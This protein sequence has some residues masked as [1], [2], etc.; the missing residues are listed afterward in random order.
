[1]SASS[2]KTPA[3]RYVFA[4]LAT[5][6]D[7]V[8][9]PL[10]WLILRVFVGGALVLE[11]WPKIMAPLAQ[12]GFVESL[13]FYPG[14]LWSPLLAGMQF[15]GGLALMVGFL[16][17]PV[18]LANSVMLGITWWFHAANPYGDAFLTQAGMEMLQAGG[19]TLLTSD[20]ARR[21]ADGG[22]AFLH[23]VQNKA[24]FLS[25]IWAVG[26]LLF[27]G[28]GGGALSVDRNIIKREF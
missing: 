18:A 25:A 14:W 12:S 22:A 17:R 2:S 21:L 8:A 9:Q 5:F 3:T 1:M 26:V 11:G 27:A 19:D 23:Q 24:E 20:G 6:Y 10:A 13:G 15:F 28:H 16:T 4:R 7:R